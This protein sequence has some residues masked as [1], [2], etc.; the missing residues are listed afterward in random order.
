MQQLEPLIA[1]CRD[2]V[3][4]LDL[5]NVKA[6]KAAHP[7]GIAIG[8]L[9]IYAP[10]E[11]VHA[12]GGL[13]VGVV[14]AGEELEIVRGDACFQSYICH[15]P[16][17]VIEL[18][19][20][21]RLDV[22]EGM[23]FPSTCDVIRN[24]S[25][26]WKLS[27]PGKW[28]H[29]L[30]L[31]QNF[32]P[33]MG[34]VFYRRILHEMYA[35]LCAMTGLA[36]DTECLRASVR[37][38]NE[39]RRLVGDL[40]AARA[41]EPWKFG[42]K[43]SYLVL[44]AGLVLPVEE[45]TTVLREYIQLCKARDVRPLDNA[46]IALRGAFCEQP[47]L[48]LIQTLERA[49]CYVVEDD[50]LPMLRWPSADVSEQGDPLDAL[51]TSWLATPCEAASRFVKDGSEKG[52]TLVDSTREAKA[53]GVIFATPSFCDPALLDRPMLQAALQ[54]SGIA[55]TSFKYAE[56]TGQMQ[57]IREQAGTFADSIKLWG[58]A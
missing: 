40:Y 38:F 41:A 43:D 37:L 49:G 14:G 45:H 58:E 15:L 25:G 18:A 28:T 1:R 13:P 52:C 50:F 17:S 51:V 5:A 53:E 46:R 42:A 19:L 9:P 23:I 27:F 47:P 7:R 4:D 57:P 56:N 30:D 44:R 29:Y 31:P 55:F 8:Y 24:L 36:P 12:A 35:E 34:G 11:I 32:E 3:E 33:E 22:L 21:G 48:A 6:W 2:L 39:N 10:R 20:T 26:I 54:R 16:R